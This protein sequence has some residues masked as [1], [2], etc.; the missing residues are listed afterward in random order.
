MSELESNLELDLKNKEKIPKEVRENIYDKIFINTIIAI[1]VVIYFGFLNLGYR[2]IEQEVFITDL[3]VFSFS[4]LVLSI[5]LLEKGYKKD[6][7]ATFLN[8]IETFCISFITLFMTYTFFESSDVTR[9]IVSLSFLYIS[10]YY[11]LKSIYVYIKE[12]KNY[13]SNLSDVR[14]IVSK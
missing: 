13:K 9:K 10:I 6:S 11:M 4:I 14:D 12:I 7:P 5:I 3:K 8:G 2:N 1:L